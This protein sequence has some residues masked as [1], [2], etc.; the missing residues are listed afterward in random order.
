MDTTSELSNFLMKVDTNIELSDVILS[1]E[2]QNKVKLFLNEIENKQKLEAYGLHPLNRLLFYGASGTGKT[3]LSKAL[4]NRLHFTM[5]YV[6]IAKALSDNSVAQNIA[7]IFKLAE[8]KKNCIIFLDECDSITMSRYTS[9][10][11]D[12]AQVRRATNSLFQQLDQMSNDNVFIAA[13]N[14]LFKIDPAFER[15]MQLK[16]EFKRP[17]LN[18]KDSI[19]RFIYDKFEIIDDVDESVEDIV[20]RRASQYAK[21]SY[22][23][24]Q[25]LVERAMKRAVLNDSNKIR[26][27][28]IYR[29]LAV[30]MRVKIN[31]G[32]QDDPDMIFRRP[33]ERQ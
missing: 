12:T 32:T 2:N 4:S 22:Y 25:G 28:E 23:E 8:E 17:E 20:D 14:L 29:D 31:L 21:L 11:G 6:D 18:I 27:S 19:K 33:E 26:T 15:R 16:L 9:D 3:F 7:S 13:T 1:E 5:L 10:Y 30:A 24:L